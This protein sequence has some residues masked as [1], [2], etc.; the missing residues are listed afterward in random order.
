MVNPH[1][2]LL[3]RQA[4]GYRGGKTG[5]APILVSASLRKVTEGSAIHE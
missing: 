4:Q 2:C 1:I 5:R 3:N